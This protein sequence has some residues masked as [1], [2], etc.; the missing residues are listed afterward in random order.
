MPGSI[1]DRLAGMRILDRVR[2]LAHVNPTNNMWKSS[3]L[4]A[5]NLGLILLRS[6]RTGKIPKLL[7]P[8]KKQ[9]EA[10]EP[11][12]F[13]K[14]SS[15]QRFTT[16]SGHVY[17]KIRIFYHPHM[18][19]AK[20]PKDLPL[21]VFIHGLGGNAT[22]FAPLLTSLVNVGPCLAIDL[23]GCG[24]SDFKPD[25]PAAYTTA[26]FAELLC[27]AIEKYRDGENDQQVVLIGHSM[28]CSI[29]A[30]LASSASPLRTKL[31]ADYIIGLIVL[32]PRSGPLSAGE[33][34][35]VNKLKY[36]P[37]PIFDLIRMIDRRGGLQSGSITRMT[38]EGADDET[39]KLQ[40]RFNDQSKSAVF[41]RFAMGML[42][43]A[44]DPHIAL[45]GREIWSGIKV[46]LF[47]VAG[48]SDGVTS[49]KEVEVIAG[50]LTKPAHAID[51]N[52]ESTVPSQLNQGSTQVDGDAAT[53]KN[54]TDSGS[55]E[56]ST[57]TVPTTAG[58]LQH[59]QYLLSSNLDQPTP[60]GDAAASNGSTPPKNEQKHTKHAFALKTTIFPSP[61]SHGLMYATST[62]RILS[63]LIETFL[64]HHIDARLSLGWQLQHMTTSGKWDVKNL[65]KW[66]AI[67]PCS[68]PIAGVFRAMKTMREVDDVHNPHEF[69]KRY[70]YEVI[71]DG[72]AIVVDISH[73]SPVYD[74][75]G[76]EE[77]GVGY[78]KFPTV[79]KLPPT[80]DEVDHFIELIDRLRRSERLQPSDEA[81]G[82]DA[83][84]RPT[85]GVHCHYGFN[86]TGF[87]IICYLVERLKYRLQDA[88]E[89]F[90]SKRSPGIKHDHFI[91]ELY[92]RYAVKMQRRGTIIG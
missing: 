44:I 31:K 54:A 61:A 13:T 52:A 28:G 33:A 51:E 82:G 36:L 79:S 70:G 89:E 55:A 27:A 25:D 68:E 85:I 11:S 83:A 56:R 9:R 91:N 80:P 63:G 39:R 12:L 66:Q 76:L 46:P 29:A 48:E 37:V 59:V 17:P 67:A 92:V 7:Q 35:T 20:L 47:L 38:G 71:P 64:A 78:V 84:R 58:D 81:K 77:G 32:C 1:T 18:Q 4:L 73:E 5:T 6:W 45:P 72:V 69:V 41:L 34:R 22:Q 43:P 3:T 2:R 49:P 88:V 24:L 87:F 86:R 10:T 14:H 26:A 40:S 60:N 50:W 42:P 21:L 57:E 62:V 19:A 16:V 53:A 8:T 75:R 90:A 30:L 15:F 23:P 74:P 65:A